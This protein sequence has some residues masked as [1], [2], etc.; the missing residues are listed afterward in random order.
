MGIFHR[1]MLKIASSLLA[2]GVM[3]HVFA[4]ENQALNA[5]AIPALPPTSVSPNDVASAPN[6]PV[7]QNPGR[8][9]QSVL[10]EI[11]EQ[12]QLLAQSSQQAPTQ[13]TAPTMLSRSA[14]SY[15]PQQPSQAL[16]P[17]P[18][19]ELTPPSVP[20]PE[21][22]SQ[23][24]EDAQRMQ[25]AA[26]TALAQ[27]HVPQQISG[28]QTALAQSQA[29]AP[30][31]SGQQT[32]PQPIALPREPVNTIPV[33]Q[34]R[35]PVSPVLTPAAKDMTPAQFQQW[36][37][38]NGY[39]KDQAPAET[40]APNVQAAAPDVTTATPNYQASQFQSAEAPRHHR[41]RSQFA[42]SKA[43]SYDQSQRVMLASVPRGHVPPI[44]DAD[45]AFNML[46]QQ[47]M[48]LTPQQVVQLRQQIDV[49]QR[50]AATPPN[51][52]PKPVSSTIMI[53]LAPGTTPPAIRLAQ[54]YVSSLV[55]VD[56]TSQPWPIAAFD[57]GN[58]KAVNIQ[59]DG[60]SNILLLQ[61]VS[62]YSDGDIV[63][64]LVGNPTPITLE[65]VSGQRVVDYR[66]DLH[67]PGIGPNTKDIPTGT[68]LPNNPNQLLLGVLDGV[69]PA[70]SKTLN[71]Q[72]ADAQAWLLGEKL[73]LRTRLTLLSPG[74]IATMVSPDGMHAYELPKTSSVLV[75]RY[76]EPAELKI[77]GF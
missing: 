76:G 72:G 15:L 31:I 16:P 44:Q 58:P 10:A 73:Y 25:L 57:I 23:A 41:S 74:W 18:T 69:S 56:S 36:L 17:G 7:N 19:A 30:Q 9:L 77:E 8:S 38:N 35:S 4:E 55:F 14:E 67:V 49:A 1:Q 60:K 3:S 50:A 70:G 32:A 11:S 6:Q 34:S 59:W 64:R 24:Y 68:A 65:L 20:A 37:R 45:I 22:N 62:A 71:V 28:Q 46:L 29:Q 43:L 63:I 12:Q 13:Q 27:P 51:I 53:N 42:K 33:N 75:S 39:A 40:L 26:Q 5:N 61:A 66:V 47:N 52:P 21:S 54:G 2:M 48:P